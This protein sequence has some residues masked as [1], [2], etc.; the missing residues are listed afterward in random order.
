MYLFDFSLTCA[1]EFSITVNNAGRVDILWVFQKK[2][3]WEHE[4]VQNLPY[5]YS[6]VATL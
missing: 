1:G 3:R 5:I 4:S 6:Y 2:S